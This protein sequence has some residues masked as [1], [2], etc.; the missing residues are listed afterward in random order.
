MEININ[1]EFNL[2]EF[3]CEKKLS[4]NISVEKIIYFPGEEIKGFV[5]IRGKGTLTNPLF[6][7]SLVKVNIFQIY[8]Y[9]YEVGTKIESDLG[10]E[11]L[12]IKIPFMEKVKQLEK[13]IQEV[14]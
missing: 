3:I 4:I 5:Y 14:I 12:K 9:E 7:Y 2:K 11:K 8:Y 1:N 6:I 10:E 13:H